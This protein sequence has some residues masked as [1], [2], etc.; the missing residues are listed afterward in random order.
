MQSL[1]DTLQVLLA[2]FAYLKMSM[3]AKSIVLGL[4][5]LI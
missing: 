3:A 2:G 1:P 5:D 4:V